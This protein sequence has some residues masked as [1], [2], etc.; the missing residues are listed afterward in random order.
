MLIDAH[1]HLFPDRLIE[2]IR[3]WFDAHAW[4]IR[5]RLGVEQCIATLKA[6]GIE[7][8]VALPYAHKPGM[9]E[10]LNA[11]TLELARRHP[12]VVPCCTVFP[13]EKGAERI[14][15]EALGSGEFHGVKMHSHVQ[16]VAPD[17]PRL[18]P[19]WRASARHRRPVVFHC[20]KE[21]ASPGYGIDVH[22]VSGASRLRRA[23][24]RHPEA[25][26]VVP[27]LGADE[28]VEM[29]AMLDEFPNLYLDTAMAIGGAFEGAMQIRSASLDVLR[30]R[31]GRILYGS[32]FPNLPYEWTRELRVIEG[33][34]LPPG[35]QAALLGGTAARLFGIA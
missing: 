12:E 10:A 9:A 21:P 34:D 7:R 29:E 1:V 19:V 6:G 30:R 23:L 18:D 8:M 27:H 13:G 31:P 2:A 16:R 15:E 32:D 17:D 26:C 20:G 22:T 28:Y 33:L 5:Y 35:A 11:F 25:I 4:D 24:S 3:R 14:L